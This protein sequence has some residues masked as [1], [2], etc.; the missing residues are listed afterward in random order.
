[1]KLKNFCRLNH[2]C[3][4]EKDKEEKETHP[5]Q[6]GGNNIDHKFVSTISRKNLKSSL[7]NHGFNWPLWCSLFLEGRT[8]FLDFGTAFVKFKVSSMRKSSSFFLFSLIGKLNREN[9][10]NNTTRLN[11][12]DRQ[13]QF[14]ITQ[15]IVTRFFFFFIWMNSNDQIFLSE[16]KEKLPTTRS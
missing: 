4:L 3:K 8:S 7:C 15:S 16:K 12:K 5:L 1:M 11:F 14:Q 2:T 9:Y 13:I 10:P 6:L